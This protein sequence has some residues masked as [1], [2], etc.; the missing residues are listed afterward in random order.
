[1]ELNTFSYGMKS[2]HDIH[3]MF[4]FSPRSQSPAVVFFCSVSGSMNES[5]LNPCQRHPQFS[6]QPE[7]C[8]VSHCFPNTQRPSVKQY[9][10]AWR[11]TRRLVQDSYAIPLWAG[12]S[13]GFE[14]SHCLHRFQRLLSVNNLMPHYNPTPLLSTI[15][16]Q[17]TC[18][19]KKL[20]GAGESTKSCSLW[21]NRE[22]TPTMA[23]CY[24]KVVQAYLNIFIQVAQPPSMQ[25]GNYRNLRCWIN[26]AIPRQGLGKPPWI[27]IMDEDHILS[28]IQ[29]NKVP[30][31]L[32]VTL[33]LGYR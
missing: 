18:A 33:K 19:F 26:L 1:M 9:H 25:H 13:T 11:N 23:T 24:L 14:R 5:F 32:S 21:T 29:L 7:R 4:S 10:V 8:L 20:G 16:H 3:L 6:D 12:E 17:S 31:L 30:T 22:I 2:F 28:L 15:F 27:K